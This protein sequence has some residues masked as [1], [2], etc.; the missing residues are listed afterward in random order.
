MSCACNELALNSRRCCCHF[1]LLGQANRAHE[2]EG[3]LLARGGG[4]G[5]WGGGCVCGS[6]THRHS[7]M[8]PAWMCIQRGVSGRPLEHL[9]W[10]NMIEIKQMET[11][12]RLISCWAGW[13]GAV[14]R[15]KGRAP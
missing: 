13:A 9:R 2:L 1:K 8:M 5:P 12:L 11:Y 3:A 10:F 14:D 7:H 15:A 6:S 4:A